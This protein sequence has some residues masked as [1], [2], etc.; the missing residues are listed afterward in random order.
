MLF[1]LAGY[2]IVYAVVYSFGAYYIY[3]LLREGP[4]GEAIPIPGAT[5]N[6]PMA[7]ADDAKS[8][9]GTLLPRKG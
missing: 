7:F 5:A 6:R 3:K 9:T 4:T 2:V 8:A 1:S